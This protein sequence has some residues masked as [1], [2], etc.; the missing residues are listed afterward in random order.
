MTSH[1]SCF[2]VLVQVEITSC[3]YATWGQAA[4]T[5]LLAQGVDVRTYAFQL[6][7]SLLMSILFIP[8]LVPSF[9]LL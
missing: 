9:L 8:S 1:V 5:A 7:V 3:P 2:I 6:F 4:V